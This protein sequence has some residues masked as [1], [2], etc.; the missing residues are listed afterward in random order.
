LEESYWKHLTVMDAGLL[1]ELMIKYGQEVWNLAFILTKRNDLADD[2]TQEV[3]LSAYRNIELFRGESSI[4]TWLLSIA[5]NTSVN[6]LRSAFMRKVTL[7]AWVSSKV[8]SPSAEHEALEQS[9]SDDIW[10]IVMKLPLKFREVLILA[11]KYDM[12]MK[13]IAGV[14]GVSEGTVKSRL[15]RAR[16][17]VKAYWKEE[18]TAYERV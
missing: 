3:F 1:R 11:G 17:K 12:S 18:G 4:K 9:L 13:E 6:Y 10:R 8:T 14:L 15:A 5:R 16:Q 7:M 2:I